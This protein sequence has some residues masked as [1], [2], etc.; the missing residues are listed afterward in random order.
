M[1]SIH[2]TVH[3]PI[4]HDYLILEAHAGQDEL[5]DFLH[6]PMHGLHSTAARRNA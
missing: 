6:I 4:M 3:Q 1:T 5:G 2:A